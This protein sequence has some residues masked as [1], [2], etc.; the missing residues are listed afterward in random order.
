[1]RTNRIRTP[2][3][4]LALAL[5]ALLAPA[6]AALAQG[7]SAITGTVVAESTGQPLIGATVSVTPDGA[8][9][10]TDEQGRF[11]IEV[12]PG[13]YTIEISFTGHATLTQQVVVGANPSDI[14]LTL[15]DD[16]RYAETIVVVGSR[17]PRSVT[18]SPV[19]IDVI[20]SEQIQEVGEIE[21]NQVMRTVAPSYNA[22]HQAI[23]DGTDHIDPASLRGLGPDQVLVLINGKRRHSSAL[24]NV[25]G[26]FGRGTVGVDLNAI[27]T[28]AIERIEVLRDGASAQYGSDA[29]AGVVNIQLKEAPGVVEASALSGITGEGDGFQLKTGL[30]YGVPVGDLGVVNLTAEFLRREA[31]DRSGP[32]TGGFY[33]DATDA[34]NDQMLEDNGLSR[35][36]ISMAIGQSEANVGMFF[37]NAR[38]PIR[39]VE[40]YSTGGLTYRQGSAAGFYRRPEQLDRTDTNIYPNGFLPQINPT[41]FDW[42]G[43]VGVRSER[44]APGLQWDISANHGGNWFDYRIENSLNASLGES[45]P[46]EFDS[47]G[48]SFS[49]TSLNAGWVLPLRTDVVKK[50]ALA[51][52]GEYR[53]DNFRIHAGE[54]DS[55]RFGGETIPGTDMPR[56]AGAQVFPG[57]QPDNEV[58]EYRNSGAGYLGVESELND[59]ILLDVAGRFENYED[60]GSTING[61]LAGRIS[62]VEQL[63]LRAAVS[64]GFRAPSL[65]QVYFNN[66]STQFVD[67]GD[68]QGLQP[69]QVL[70]ANNVGPIAEA[71]GIPALEEETS[72]NV[73]GG[74]TAQPIENLSITADAYYITIDNRIVLTTQFTGAIEGVADLLE[75]FGANAAQ[76]F[77]N[78][79]D[80]RTV[81]TDIVVDYWSDIGRGRFG[82]TAAANFT[83]TTVEDINIPQGVADRFAEGD[84]GAVQDV[85]FNREEKN[86][87]QDALPR[88]KGLLQ[89]RYSI[90]PFAGLL[91]ANYYG[92]VKFKPVDRM[93][94]ET[95][96]A[97]VTLDADVGYEVF[98]GFKAAIGANNLLNTFPDE[99]TNELNVA[100]GQFIYSRRVTQ[101]GI[102]GGFYYLRLQYVY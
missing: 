84:L 87:L 19:P 56:Q 36:D 91:R 86:R 48:F 45:S 27:P 11:R 57:F 28:S 69:R 44:D 64:N 12:P 83:R 33:P 100:D 31:T 71:F 40:A 93:Q 65:H 76:F 53:V 39:S 7:P 20:T 68:G 75:P 70:T 16:P 72:L 24:T 102:N 23:S 82:A 1:M 54:P 30:N 60:F 51:G 47:G 97:K 21:T 35:D 67:A 26:T 10:I 73:S 58:N 4:C 13:T 34:E 74:I 32:W 95:F 61:K 41:I 92:E 80:T 3:V 46:R 63:A 50:L 17:T 15:R 77:A 78:A 22:S 94:D 85:I 66:T 2:L 62:V 37:M 38:I 55:Y 18:R 79:V 99:Q 43:G 98:K 8:G 25:N 96:G 88:Q 81:G 5:A 42:S 101:F 6:R 14:S 49:Q 90:G 29:I 89:G 52:G 59:R 9:A